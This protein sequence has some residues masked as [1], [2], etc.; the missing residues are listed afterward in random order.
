[1]IR[2]L[3]TLI[4]AVLLMG[5]SSCKDENITPRP[6]QQSRTV[7]IY[8]VA[9][10]NLA[11]YLEKDIDEMIAAAPDVD[12]LGDNVNVLLYSVASKNATE[13]TL[14]RLETNPFGGYA[15]QTLKSYDRDKYSTDP[16]RMTEVYADVRKYAAADRY[17]LIFWSHGTG[18][19]PDF[20]THAGSRMQRSFGWDSTASGDVDKC[21]I[22]ELADAIP[23]GMF[24]YI[25]FDACYM[26]GVEVV[27][28]LR[29]KCDYIGGYPTED[30]SYGMNYED[31]LPRLA[32]PEP[33][34][35]GTAEAF[36][37]YYT[38]SNMAVTV[39]LISTAALENLAN[40]AAAVYSAGERPESAF[41][42]MDYGRSPCQGLY[43][44]GQFT[45]AY[46]NNNDS[47][48]SNLISALTDA[49]S[50]VLI[51]GGC[52]SKNFYGTENAFKPEEYSGL[53]CHFPDTY[54][55]DK[56][57]YFQS[58]DWTKATNP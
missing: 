29:D 51:Y 19:I 36:F 55:R 18:W 9:S 56:E 43:D 23:S 50:D 48:S 4:S 17:G 57:A 33:D 58:L 21:D 13:A 22:I 25:W 54:T 5:L 46:F 16:E 8:A 53:S 41:G 52:S 6:A 12:G 45:R 31:T 11:S 39:S 38:A 37:N 26:M 20:Y 3:L 42:M 7:L 34:L 28:Q 30:W 47:N 15:F 49:L 44:F 2:F 40:A 14:S 24:D 35:V 32:A 27:F 1:M 10:N